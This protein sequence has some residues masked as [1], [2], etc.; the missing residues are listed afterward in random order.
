MRIA[1]ILGTRPE[2]IKMAPVIRALEGDSAFDHSLIVTG[3]H[4]ELLD[5]ALDLF[6][7]KPAHDLNIMQE[8]Q[9]LDEILTRALSRL[10]EIVCEEQPECILVHGDT[11]TTLAGALTGFYN[12]I[13]VGHVE[14]GLRTVDRFLPYPE[15]INRRLV[16]EIASYYFCPTPSAA[17]NLKKAGLTEGEVLVTGNTVVDAVRMAAALPQQPPRELVAFA[18]RFPE[19]IVVT[20]H[21]RENWGEPLQRIGQALAS[22]ARANDDVGIAVCLHPNPL[23]REG[24]EPL[25]AGLVNVMLTPAPDYG[26]FVKLMQGAWFILTDSGGIQ[27]EACALEKFVLVLRE[28]TERPEA[29]E[30]GF[31]K[32]IGTDS[33]RIETQMEYAL[34]AVRAGKLP[35]R[36]VPNPFGDGRAAERIVEFLRAKLG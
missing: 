14:A 29:V 21:R 9:R 10:S 27:E 24:L 28:H 3:Q 5:Q 12:H 35:P 19:Y 8:G 36:G 4:R 17:E 11:S 18:E 34:N 16:D 32:V 23:L 31:A 1:T 20:A 33:Q 7:L 15:E 30:A 13:P 6:S 25:L 2:A 22:F 26:A